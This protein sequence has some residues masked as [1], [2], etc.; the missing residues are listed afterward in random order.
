MR[1]LVWILAIL[2][3]ILHQD[4]WW[5]DSTTMVFGFMPIG[6]FYHAL[7]SV[8]A[9]GLWALA[10]K[11]AWPTHLEE[12]ADEFDDQETVQSGGESS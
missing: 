2:L 12:W 3:A 7:F 9:G 1:R 8:A 4:L 11:F 6:L 10:V 5:W